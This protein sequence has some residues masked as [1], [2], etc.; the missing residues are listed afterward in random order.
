MNQAEKLR[1]TYWIKSKNLYI[2]L[3]DACS[4]DKRSKSTKKC[5]IRRKLKF[6]KKPKI[7]NK[8]INQTA[9]GSNDDK[10]IQLIDPNE[11]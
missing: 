1:K 11:T 4:E 2:Y 5:V 8:K 7:I 6:N 3:I 9:L 10:R